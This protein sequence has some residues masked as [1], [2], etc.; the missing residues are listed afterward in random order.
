MYE[1]GVAEDPM[2]VDDIF[3]RHATPAELAYNSPYLKLS[4]SMS[5]PTSAY[6]QRHG[7]V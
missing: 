5:F 1:Y 2:Y 3:I 7:D 4:I 6:K